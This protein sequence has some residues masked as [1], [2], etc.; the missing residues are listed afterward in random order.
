MWYI[1]SQEKEHTGVWAVFADFRG[2]QP[3]HRFTPLLC[4]LYTCLCVKSESLA[5]RTDEA[6]RLTRGADA[7]GLIP[8]IPPCVVSRSLKTGK[9]TTG[10]LNKSISP[11]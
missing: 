8:G 6:K 5:L 9:H 3:P 2:F 10:K 11:Y 1:V 7:M 4:G